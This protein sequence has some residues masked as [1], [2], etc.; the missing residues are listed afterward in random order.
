MEY[1]DEYA[2]KDLYLAAFLSVKRIP[3]YKVEKYGHTNVNRTPL[4]QKANTP[5]YFIF[6]DRDRCEELEDVF[7]SGAGE[8]AMVNVRDF[9]TALRDLR[10]RAYSVSRIVNNITRKY[11]GH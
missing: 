7:W 9:A 11:E 4:N 2:T 8:E 10:T 5:A 1:I 3:I 6:G